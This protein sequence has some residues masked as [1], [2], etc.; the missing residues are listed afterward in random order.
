MAR[1]E[2]PFEVATVGTG[3]TATAINSALQTMEQAGDKQSLARLTAHFANNLADELTGLATQHGIKLQVDSVKTDLGG[4]TMDDGVYT[5]TPQITAIVRGDRGDTK[6]LMQVVNEA[7]EQQGGNI[8]RRPSAKELYDPAVEKQPVVSFETGQMTTAQRTAFVT[9]LAKIR[10]SNGNRIFTGYT[11]SDKGV[12]IGGQFYDGN[13]AAS[14]RTN[15]PSINATMKKHGVAAHVMEEM[16]VPSYRSSDPV[17]P[18]PFR[19]AV[20]KLFYDKAVSGIAANAPTS[21][22]QT[23]NV[24]ANLKSRLK[25]NETMFIGREELDALAKAIT[26]S[27]SMSADQALARAGQSMEI[28][29]TKKM[30]SAFADYLSGKKSKF[31]AL[32]AE[33]KKVVSGYI[34]QARETAKT[35]RDQEAAFS[36]AAKDGIRKRRAEIADRYDPQRAFDEIDAADLMGYMSQTEVAQ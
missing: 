28:P 32:P 14:V 35:L 22:M 9:D 16:I 24:E 26:E 29:G 10:D 7:V 13:F 4:F 6:Y 25:K 15:L 19:D 5:E 21:V 18:S 36:K 8:F 33:D 27:E 17:S 1:Q 34:K 23:A 30:Q 12:F 2:L 3:R 20:Q 31:E 11:P